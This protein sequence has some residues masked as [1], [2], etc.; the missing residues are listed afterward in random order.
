MEA[1]IRAALERYSEEKREGLRAVQE[2][3]KRQV[4]NYSA[5]MARQLELL[6][7]KEKEL[8]EA[9][10]QSM[11]QSRLLDV[12]LQK[13]YQSRPKD[14]SFQLPAIKPRSPTHTTSTELS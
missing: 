9:N 11:Q 8:I 5:E 2:Q 1:G 4:L 6:A 13:M 7:Q 3:E 10:S 12:Q 14:S